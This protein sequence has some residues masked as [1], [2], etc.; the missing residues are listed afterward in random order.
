MAGARS[1]AEPKRGLLGV[2]LKAGQPA[3]PYILRG[4]RFYKGLRSAR[5]IARLTALMEK[6]G[7]EVLLVETR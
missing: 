4:L 6:A 5:D 3:R 7:K 1:L 2:S